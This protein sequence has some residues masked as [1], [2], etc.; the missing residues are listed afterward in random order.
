[1]ST[2]TPR[3]DQTSQRLPH[4]PALRATDQ[5]AGAQR[6]NKPSAAHPAPRA[7]PA[8]AASTTARWAYA[9]SPICQGGVGSK[10][11]TRWSRRPAPTANLCA[12]KTATKSN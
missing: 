6:A 7:D 12:C 9:A 2:M 10:V 5:K 4:S 1:M 11:R 3:A 8:P